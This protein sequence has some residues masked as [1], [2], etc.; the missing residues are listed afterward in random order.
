MC[1][2]AATARSTPESP[3]MWRA[4]TPSMPRAGRALHP[5]QSAASA[6]PGAG[7]R[8]PLRGAEGRTRV[9]APA[10]RRQAGLSAAT[11]SRGRG[12]LSFHVATGLRQHRLTSLNKH[13]RHSLLGSHL[14]VIAIQGDQDENERSPLMLASLLAAS[15]LFAAQAGRIRMAERASAPRNQSAPAPSGYRINRELKD[16]KISRDEARKLHREDRDIRQQEQGMAKMNA[17]HHQAGA[18]HAEPGRKP[19]QPTD[20][21]RQLIA[22][23]KKKPAKRRASLSQNLA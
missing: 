16:G 22:P 1:C 15:L 18:K 10:P 4:A 12:F 13:L 8:R 11:R 21:E 6:G 20:Q 7:L 3:P 19:G 17:P 23:S 9:Q 2:A 14:A 5:A